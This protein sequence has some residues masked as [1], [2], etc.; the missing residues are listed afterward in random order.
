MTRCPE[1]GQNSR[2]VTLISQAVAS[3]DDCARQTEKLST[4]DPEPLGTVRATTVLFWQL[5]ITAERDGS[6]KFTTV[7]TRAILM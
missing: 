4:A 1:P 3:I 7:I 5:I 6:I 2:P